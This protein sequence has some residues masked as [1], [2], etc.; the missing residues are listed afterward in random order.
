MGYSSA[1]SILEAKEKGVDLQA[2]LRGG[3]THEGK[4]TLAD[5]EFNE[6]VWEV[7]PDVSHHEGSH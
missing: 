4:K 3:E 7:N 5:F 1:K 2:P 6:A